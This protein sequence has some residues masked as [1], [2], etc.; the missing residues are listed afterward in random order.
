MDN[1]LIVGD[2]NGHDILWH[3]SICD[4]RGATLAGE[5]EAS[6]FVVLNTEQQTRSPVHGN[7][8]SPDIAAISSSLATAAEWRVETRLNSDHLPAIVSIM[9]DAA[10]TTSRKTTYINLAKANWTKFAKEV[11]D[12]LDLVPAPISVSRDERTFRD[13]L[14]TASKHHI[15]SGRHVFQKQPLPAEALPLIQQRDEL[16]ASDPTSSEIPELNDCITSIIQQSK[17]DKWRESMSSFNPRTDIKKLWRTVK[18]LENRPSAPT[19]CAISFGTKTYSD[20]GVIANHL[21]K[22]FTAPRVHK[23][24]KRMR[25]LIRSIKRQ[26]RSVTISFSPDEVQKAISNAKNSKAFGPDGLTI[27]HLKHLGPKGIGYL[28]DLFN[29]SLERSQLPAIWKRS[30]IIPLLKPGKDA[31]I[32]TSYR[33]VSL[34]CPGV[35]VLESLVLPLLAE[36]LRPVVH[37]HGFRAKHSTTS[38]LLHVSHAV[39]SGFN[40][41]KPPYRTVLVALDLTKAFDCV[42][43]FELLSKINNSSLPGTLKRWT[44]CYL[45]GRQACTIFRQN[46]SRARIVHCGVPQGSVISPALFNSYVADMPEPTE[47]VTIV[48]YADDLSVFTTG[49]NIQQLE[50]RLNAYLPSVEAF[51]SQRKLDISAAKSTVTLFSPDPRQSLI[52]PDV[53]IDGTRLPLERNPKILG[54]TFDTM[55]T[56]SDHCKNIG[57][58]A[59]QRNNILRALSGTSW[60][61]DKESILMT[62]KAITR[63]LMNYAAPV[64]APVASSSSFSALQRSQNSALRIATGCVRMSSV[65]HLHQETLCLPIKAHSDMLCAQYLAS[66]QDPD[67]PCHQLTVNPRAPRCMKKTMNAFS[68][69]VNR[70]RRDLDDDSSTKSISKKIHTNF[71]ARHLERLAVNPVL[72]RRPPPIHQ[73][74]RTLPRSARTSLAQLRSGYSPRLH[75]YQHRLDP[76]VPNSCPDCHVSP[77]DTP[78]L[79]HCTAKPI[80]AV[81]QDLWAKPAHAARELGLIT[82]PPPPRL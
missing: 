27:L 44:S 68:S 62:Y 7:A 39:A 10:P 46:K 47:D 13:I 42:D 53:R 49:A 33:P 15:P 76:R 63:S 36:H 18:G 26:P 11:E 29:L 23:S 19:N 40:Q 78:H 51:F 74:E 67:H 35:K 21:N 20:P 24:D 17:R 50:D 45:R 12:A 52:H 72:G 31:L 57:A 6:N 1:T 22:Q 56:F 34:L 58:R 69:E 16:R 75:S 54:V 5:I 80:N 55:F 2:I 79:F 38:A 70:A 43:H 9:G 73:E 28:C 82:E 60:G 71:V 61:Q 66:C 59:T 77:H 14:L 65:D 41:S 3:S 25:K 8:T 81:I 32:S 48:S 37:Q 30:T 64:W 4:M